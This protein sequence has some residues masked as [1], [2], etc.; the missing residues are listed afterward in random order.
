VAGRVGLGGGLGERGGVM[1]APGRRNC[2]PVSPDPHGPDAA[3]VNH[4]VA[5]YAR[6][7]T[8]RRSSKFRVATLVARCDVAPLIYPLS[9]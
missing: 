8:W 3:R 9:A 7:Q 1:G 2:H 5:P 4:E 6:E